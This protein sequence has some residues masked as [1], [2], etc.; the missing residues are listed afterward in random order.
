MTPPV[1]AAVVGCGAISK[2]HLSFIAATPWIDLVGV[3]DLSPATREY[4]ARRY[5]ARQAYASLETMLAES[6]PEVVH[7]LTPPASHPAV[8]AACLEADAN[9]ICEKPI[10]PSAAEL[11]TLLE[12]ATR[13]GLLIIERQNL[14]FN[15]HVLTIKQLIADGEL[16]EILDVEVRIALDIASSAASSATRTSP[17]R[18]P[19]WRAERSTTSC[20]TWPTA[21]CRSSLTARSPT[22]TPSGAI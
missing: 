15:D 7:V 21:R 12:I 5:G 14:R 11:E 3:S 16:G 18:S 10:A 2:E 1:R 17:A 19:T 22:S 13:R 8:A 9:V 4:A 20:R 6:R